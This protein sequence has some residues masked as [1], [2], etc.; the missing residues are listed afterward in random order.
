MSAR[1]P[2]IAARVEEPGRADRAVEPVR[3]QP[4]R[5][6]DAA[7]RAVRD[8]LAGHDGRR[9]RRSARRSRPRR[10]G[11]SRRRPARPRR[12]APSVVTPGLSTMTSLP[13]LHRPDGDAGP[14]AG[15]GGAA[16]STSIEGSSSSASPIDRLASVGK[17]SRNPSSTRGSLVCGSIAGAGRAGLQEAADH[18]ED[19]AV[20]E[21]DRGKA[22]SG[23]SLPSDAPVADAD[24]PGPSAGRRRRGRSGVSGGFGRQFG[25]QLVVFGRPNSLSTS[26]LS[27]GAMASVTS[28]TA[29]PG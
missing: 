3:A 12:A 29:G 10:C 7:D 18:M 9:A 2:P 27:C 16:R 23:L 22:H 28:F 13:R 19:V 6:H 8:Q 4:D 21:T 14:V 15:N 1:M 26:W 20:V 25:D 11:R 5:L 24:S 17:R